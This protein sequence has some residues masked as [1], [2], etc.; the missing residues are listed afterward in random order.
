L[1][2]M[3]PVFF[4]AAGSV[5]RVTLTFICYNSKVSLSS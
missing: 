4:G 2:D 5:V 3:G 1:A